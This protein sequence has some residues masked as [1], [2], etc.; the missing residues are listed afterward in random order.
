MFENPPEPPQFMEHESEINVDIQIKNHRAK[1][2]WKRFLVLSLVSLILVTTSTLYFKLAEPNISPVNIAVLA[3]VN[4]LGIIF[5][6]VGCYFCNMWQVEEIQKRAFAES[7][8]QVKETLAGDIAN[9][10]SEK[11]NSAIEESDK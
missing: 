9:H 7:M 4:L 1:Y 8:E 11:L 10:L 6:F 5:G 3:G 2:L